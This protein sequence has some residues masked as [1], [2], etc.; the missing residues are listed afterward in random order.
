[1]VEVVVVVVVVPFVLASFPLA[2]TAFPDASPGILASSEL[3]FHS[4]CLPFAVA[5]ASERQPQGLSQPVED[6]MENIYICLRSPIS[7]RG[8]R[9]RIP[10][11]EIRLVFL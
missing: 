1:V 8:L 3:A 6:S 10:S 7:L 2:S 11:C 9:C 4:S 5:S